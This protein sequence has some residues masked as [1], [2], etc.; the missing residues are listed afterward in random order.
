MTALE[1]QVKENAR[2]LVVWVSVVEIAL[3]QEETAGGVLVDRYAEGDLQGPNLGG[4]GLIKVKF[5]AE[6]AVP[7][8]AELKG[9]GGWSFYGGRGFRWPVFG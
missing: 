8:V 3:L 5:A 1:V 6:G 2:R 9:L 4:D 7:V